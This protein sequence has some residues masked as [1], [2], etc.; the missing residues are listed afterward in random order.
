MSRSIADTL[1][2]QEGTVV[3]TFREMAI[4]VGII[5]ERYSRS[6]EMMALSNKLS[7][8]ASHAAGEVAMKLI[9]QMKQERTPPT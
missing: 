6:P 7:K 3:L 8:A 4:L 1:D 5:A 9:E 2:A